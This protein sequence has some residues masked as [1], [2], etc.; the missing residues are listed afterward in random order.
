MGYYQF[1]VV[2]RPFP[3]HHL[4]IAQLQPLRQ[5]RAMRVM[6]QPMQL[7]THKNGRRT[8]GRAEFLGNRITA[9]GPQQGGKVAPQCRGGSK[10][11]VA[12]VLA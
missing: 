12:G 3:P 10:P 2:L 8:L 6:A 11:V 9:P 4:P 5:H 1:G 7:S